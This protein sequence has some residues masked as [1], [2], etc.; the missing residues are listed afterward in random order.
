MD[1]DIS[2]P[3]CHR[4]D[5]VQNVK[6]LHADGISTSYSS[7]LSTGFAVTSAGLVPVLGASAGERTHTT[8]LARSMAP[9]PLLRPTGRLVLCGILLL[10]PALA[11]LGPMA[12]YVF[13]PEDVGVLMALFVAVTVVTGLAAP[14]VLMLGIAYGRSRYNSRIWRGR[15]AAH[16]VWS[17]GYY[18]HRCGVAYWPR[19]PSSGIPA[20]KAFA[21]QH[22]RQHVWNVGGYVG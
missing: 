13:H 10:L 15:A 21:P 14:S 9:E 6:A 18:C 16:A 4:I 8:A 20:R 19:S 11:A 22:F 17:A 3:L 7:D 12:W 5:A 1:T 2:C